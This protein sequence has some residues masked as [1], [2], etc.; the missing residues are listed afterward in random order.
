MLRSGAGSQY[1]NAKLAADQ[2]SK[3]SATCVTF[4]E[5]NTVDIAKE[6]IAMFE[7]IEAEAAASAGRVATTDGNDVA[8]ASASAVADDPK[9]CVYFDKFCDLVENTKFK[10]AVTTISRFYRT[11]LDAPG[12]SS[13]DV[14]NNEDTAKT[15]M[16]L[17][18]TLI[19]GFRSCLLGCEEVLNLA[20]VTYD[21]SNFD[22]EEVA[23]AADWLFE[24]TSLLLEI[25]LSDPQRLAIAE[26]NSRACRIQAL[27]SATKNEGTAAVAAPDAQ[28]KT[29]AECWEACTSITLAAEPLSAGDKCIFVQNFNEKL[30]VAMLENHR[31]KILSSVR[32]IAEEPG[33]VPS[34]FVRVA[35]EL[36]GVLPV[37]V[38]HITSSISTWLALKVSTDEMRRGKQPGVI[39]CT[40]LLQRCATAVAPIATRDDWKSMRS[41][42][43]KEWQ[44]SLDNL[45][46]DPE[47]FKQLLVKYQVPVEKALEKW[48]F[49]ETPFMEK[50]VP[51]PELQ[52]DTQKMEGLILGGRKS[53][54]VLEDLKRQGQAAFPWMAAEEYTSVIVKKTDAIPALRTNVHN[55]GVILG[56]IILGNGVLTGTLNVRTKKMVTEHYRVDLV[57]LPSMLQKKLTEWQAAGGNQKS[58][59]KGKTQSGS[60][61]VTEKTEQQNAEPKSKRFK[62]SKESKAFALES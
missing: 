31:G 17:A 56:S 24:T 11:M 60:E 13:V 36:A 51:S 30:R 52:R 53:I 6:I 48:D 16:A 14:K 10:M 54:V 4:L 23:N 5:P 49:T 21:T 3:S 50:T 37:E 45:T 59:P 8:S 28:L 38:Q 42:A 40:S 15:A 43:V 34:S 26:L 57:D 41:I 1:N 7:V 22:F 20:A 19:S 12:G 55:T 35:E 18:A 58:N 2:V 46:S 39:H 32:S 62:R 33:Q 25:V 47:A 61:S 29:L 44:S 9:P 27:L